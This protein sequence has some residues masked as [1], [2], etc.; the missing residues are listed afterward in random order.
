MGS[1]Q[2]REDR[3]GYIA[4]WR[5]PDGN[6]RSKSFAKGE[7]VRFV[8]KTEADKMEGNYLD[9]RRARMTVATW[10]E[11]FRELR[12]RK[13]SRHRRAGGD[14]PSCPRAP[15]LGQPGDGVDPQ[16]R[17]QRYVDALSAALA[18]STVRR[19]Y[20][21]LHVFFQEAVDMD[22]PV[23]LRNPCKKV[24][25]PDP[26]DRD[27]RFFTPA[28]IE[29]L[30]E[31]FHPRFRVMVLVGCYAGLLSVS[32]LRCERSTCCSP[33]IS[34][35]CE[36]ERSTQRPGPWSSG[37][38]RPGIRGVGWTS[39]ASC[40]T[41]SPPTASSIRPPRMGGVRVGSSRSQTASPSVPATGVG[42][43]GPR[44]SPG[45]ASNRPR[46]TQCVIPSS[47]S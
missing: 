13:R 30:Y 40:S 42:G 23:I 7:A 24:V 9:P 17:L 38:S 10:A 22:P 31:A 46:P 20:G 43:S 36:K 6:R 4:R 37:R 19:E 5:D 41:S 33:R 29:A 21:L 32:R 11:Q 28:E 34:S 45:P 18:P 47:A 26:D 27:Q 12:A 3:P 2:K 35:T 44:P 16:T 8:T 15:G 39:P 14:V 25:L 1:I